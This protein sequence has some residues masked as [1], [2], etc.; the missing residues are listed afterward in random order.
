MQ[1]VS[2]D[3]KFQ[4]NGVYKMTRRRQKRRSG[5]RRQ[6]LR[7]IGQWIGAPVK[8]QKGIFG[9]RIAKAL[10]TALVEP[11]DD[12]LTPTQAAF[13]LAL[14]RKLLEENGG[15][16]Q[17]LKVKAIRLSALFEALP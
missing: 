4:I 10:A 6:N 8:D 5:W 17:P 14:Y 2:A 16:K 7:A 12:A 1:V 15:Q 3:A 13:V 11:G 9:N